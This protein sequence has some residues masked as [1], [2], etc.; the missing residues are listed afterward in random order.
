[1][2]RLFIRTLEILTQ[3]LLNAH[4]NVR[5]KEVKGTLIAAD[6]TDVLLLLMYHW[7]Q[8]MTNIYIFT[9]SQAGKILDLV[10]EAGLIVTS[11]FMH[12]QGN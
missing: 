1:M 11:C 8:N 7:K 10:G 9:D 6:D 4:F 5:L 12:G 2:A 3:W